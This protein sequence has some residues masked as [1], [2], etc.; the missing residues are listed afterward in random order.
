MAANPES[1]RQLEAKLAGDAQFAA[2]AQA[3][4]LWWFQ[5]SKYQPGDAGRYPIARVWEKNW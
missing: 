5:R 2:D 4:L 1:R 3:R